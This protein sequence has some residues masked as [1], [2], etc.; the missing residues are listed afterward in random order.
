MKKQKLIGRAGYVIESSGDFRT[1]KIA[2]RVRNG[3]FSD[4]FFRIEGQANLDNNSDC[5][6]AL[7]LENQPNLFD[8]GFDRSIGILGMISKAIQ[9]QKAPRA[10]VGTDGKAYLAQCELAR[11]LQALQALGVH[12]TIFSTWTEAFEFS[13]N[14][15]EEE[16][17]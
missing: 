14:L 2:L 3:Q 4:L 15:K 12:V 8:Y 17:G 11:L 13:Y 1:V 16:N 5:F 10:K 6:Y 9:K 7:R